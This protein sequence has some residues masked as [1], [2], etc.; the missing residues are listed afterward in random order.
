VVAALTVTQLARVLAD[1]LTRANIEY[2]IGGAISGSYWGVPRATVDVDVTVFAVPESLPRALDALAS[3]GCVF[4]RAEAVRDALS[5]GTFRADHAGIRV[6]VYVPDVPLY[7]E[8][9]RRRR[10]V[11]LEGSPAQIWSPEIIVAFKMLYFRSKDRPDVERILEAQRATFEFDT[12]RRWLV[13]SVG[14]SDER[15]VWWDQ[16]ASKIRPK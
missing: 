9:L 5:R 7:E 16:T 6:D 12:V 13:E 11:D 8:A 14:P 10:T 3:A 1:A 2:G 15:V 4:D